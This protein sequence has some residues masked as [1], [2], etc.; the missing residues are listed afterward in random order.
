MTESKRARLHHWGS[1]SINGTAVIRHAHVLTFKHKNT[2]WVWSTISLKFKYKYILTFMVVH[3]LGLH[4]KGSHHKTHVDFWLQI[5]CLVLYIIVKR[6]ASESPYSRC[7][8]VVIKLVHQPAV[9]VEVQISLLM[10]P[11]THTARLL[12][13]EG[14]CVSV[15]VSE[16]E[17]ERGDVCERESVRVNEIEGAH[18]LWSYLCLCC[19][20][21]CL[22]YIP[23]VFLS[24]PPASSVS[25]LTLSFSLSQCVSCHQTVIPS[26]P[27]CLFMYLPHSVSASLCSLFPSY[28]SQ[29]FRLFVCLVGKEGL[30][31]VA[32]EK[33]RDT[34]REGEGCMGRGW[35]SKR[36]KREQEKWMRKQRGEKREKRKRQIRGIYKQQ[37]RQSKR[38]GEVA[39]GAKERDSVRWRVQE[40]RGDK[41]ELGWSVPLYYSAYKQSDCGEC[42]CRFISTC[43][44]V[45]CVCACVYVCN[46]SA[47]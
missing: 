37:G 33:D 29:S 22:F 23:S 32:Q 10:L 7:V 47:T 24:H 15:W 11:H 1:N 8:Y 30:H 45:V 12:L 27:L 41:G 20:W 16:K 36:A 44:Q 5:L 6:C 14:E 21:S 43:W 13:L 38:E 25:I 4:G 46:Y 26:I 39:K 3:L 9:C 17:R 28:S 34:Q 40:V 31:T 42:I 35:N 2:S 18:A 19:H